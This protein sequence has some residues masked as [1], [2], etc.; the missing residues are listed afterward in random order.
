MVVSPVW[1]LLRYCYIRIFLLETVHLSSG[2]MV[3]NAWCNCL[4]TVSC[5]TLCGLN[6]HLR[7]K[8]NDINSFP[9]NA[10]PLCLIGYVVVVFRENGWKTQLVK[11]HKLRV[12]DVI[13]EVD[14]E[15]Y[16]AL[17]SVAPHHK[18]FILLNRF[19]SSRIMLV[20]YK[21]FL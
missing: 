15:L 10:L 16:F 2:R 8:L 1:T 17:R 14:P 12:Y 9:T 11:F 19:A 6:Y 13:R 21:T 5:V 7:L 4:R 18:D 3:A 20:G